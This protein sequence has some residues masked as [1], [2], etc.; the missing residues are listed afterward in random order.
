MMRMLPLRL[1]PGQD[2]RRALEAAVAGQGVEA[3]FVVSGIGSLG[4]AAVRLA[5][6][7]QAGSLQGEFEILTLAG[8][9]AT[10]G[11]HLHAALSG[12]DGQVF[13]GHVA[14]GCLVRTTAEVLLAL[15][16]EWSFSRQY[17]PATGYEEL[18][19]SPRRPRGSG[20]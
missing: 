3:A 7:P 16:P 17:E 14:Y 4:V 19:V 20:E 6:A 8:S 1:L 15:L 10:H 18:V 13:G 12:A 5:G 2:L 9:V 11:S